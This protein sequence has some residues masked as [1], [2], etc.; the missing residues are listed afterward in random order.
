M[1]EERKTSTNFRKSSINFMFTPKISDVKISLPNMSNIQ[2]Q[3]IRT[4]SLPNYD[5]SYYPPEYGTCEHPGIVREFAGA[6]CYSNNSVTFYY[7][8]SRKFWKFAVALGVKQNI[9]PRTALV[10]LDFAVSNFLVISTNVG[11]TER[12]PLAES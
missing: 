9:T 1:K 7:M 4:V 12:R 8:D 2:N 3:S 6:Y 11:Y 10:L 5:S